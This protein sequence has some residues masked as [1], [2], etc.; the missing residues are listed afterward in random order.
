MKTTFYLV[1]H[2]KSEANGQGKFCGQTDS[3]LSDQGRKQAALTADYLADRPIEAFYASDL[4]RAFETVQIVAKPHHKPV[5]PDVAFREMNFGS[6]EGRNWDTL[7]SLYPK[8]CLLWQEQIARV[9]FPGGETVTAVFERMKNRMEQFAQQ[10]EGKTVCIGSHGMAI[11]CF[12][13][14]LADDPVGEMQRLSWAGNAT[15]TTVLYEDG[16]FT[17]KQYGEGAFLGNLFSTITS[18]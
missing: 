13:G 3:P 8:E 9:D 6:W 7:Q 17:L 2:G 12:C 15:V 10:Y 18:K 16:R 11:R 4:S 14:L 1:R 5:I